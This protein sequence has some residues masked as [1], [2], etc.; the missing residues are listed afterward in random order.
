MITKLMTVPIQKYEYSN[1]P[2][3]FFYPSKSLSVY[4]PRV[5]SLFIRLREAQASCHRYLGSQITG[6]VSGDV[7][8]GYLPE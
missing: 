3:C 5:A 7:N 6:L 8:L 4:F 1:L 2:S